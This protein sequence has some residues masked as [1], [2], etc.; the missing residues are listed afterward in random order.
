M[1]LYPSI[2]QI[3]KLSVPIMMGSA[4]QNIIALSDS[5]LLFHKGKIDF[6]AIGLVSI[7]YLIISSIGYGFSKGGQI[8]I[9]RKLG[10]GHKD[11][12]G[13]AFYA[14]FYFQ[15]ILACFLFIFM[16][17]AGP[18]LFKFLIHNQEISTKCI[19]FLDWRAYG[20]F[21][22]YAGVSIVA[23]YTGVARTT[24][25]IIDTA[26]LLLANIF[27]NYAFIFGKFGF[28]EWGI[29]GAGL[30]STI[31]ELIAIVVFFIY[32]IFDKEAIYYRIFRPYKVNW[33]QIKEQLSIGTPIVAQAIVGMGSWLI[34]FMVVEN[35]IGEDA[36]AISNL[37]RNVYLL[38]SIPCWGFASGINTMVSNLI[39]QKKHDLVWKA[40]V[41]T[42]IICLCVT[43]I[44]SFPILFYPE[45]SIKYILFNEE[46]N[47]IDQSRGLFQVLFGI[48]LV[49]AVGGVFFNGLAGTGATFYGLK[50]QFYCALFYLAF[51]YFT[52]IVWNV[53][54]N[55]AWSSEIFYWGIILFFSGH[56]IY[57]KKWIKEKPIK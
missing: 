17:T 10:Q 11:E 9:A 53:G 21:I 8:I 56:Y 43:F 47:L 13:Q 39:G 29:Y 55:W 1:E 16:K 52:I 2:R 19:E 50:I 22:S 5:V 12:V 40:V 41:K 6:A 51:I 27:L 37:G 46:T 14:M 4:V 54:L 20:I 57:F 48:L 28:P 23:L 49:F 31:A 18:F 7:F 32:M 36:L 30:A 34:F 35:H 25:I 33:E 15:M 3:L 38:L 42:S 24:F 44:I 26:I 45:Y